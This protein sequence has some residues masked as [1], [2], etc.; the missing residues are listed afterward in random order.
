MNLKTAFDQ[1]QQHVN[2][3]PD[4]VKI[5]RDRKNHFV[6]GLSGG[7]G[8]VDVWLSGSLRRLTQLDPVHDVDLVLE[9]SPEAYPGWG[10]PGSSSAEA[11]EFTRSWV[12]EQLGDPDGAHAQLVRLARPGNRA[13]KCFIDDPDEPDAFTV[14]VMPALRKTDGTLLIPAAD[15][16]DWINA[17][18]EHLIR[19]VGT[20]QETWDFYVPMIRL[21]KDWRFQVKDGVAIKSLFMEV[22]ALECL[23]TGLERPQALS[24]FFTRAAVRV[25]QSIEDPAGLCGPIQPDLDITELRDALSRA[26][27]LAAAA[28]AAQ[29]N[30]AED[31]AMR[32]WQ[33]VL[34]WNFPAPVES[35]ASK[36]FGAPALVT[37][38]VVRDTPQG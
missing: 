17:D 28:C 33:E 6:A 34:G 27:D 12:K 22:L 23:P 2:A 4:L 26:D 21:I 38:G 19:E 13:V 24:R 16:A 37:S 36:I 14:D 3:D 1:F 25:N 8:V 20:R 18:P 31:K 10:L 35:K 5:A 32:L 15:D 11:V 9:V 29:D 30:G 7:E